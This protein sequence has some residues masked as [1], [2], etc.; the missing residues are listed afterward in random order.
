M[1]DDVIILEGCP[2]LG[3]DIVEAGDT[4]KCVYIS[5]SNPVTVDM[6]TM[7]I[8][9]CQDQFGSN[10]TLASMSDWTSKLS[11]YIQQN[12]DQR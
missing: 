6:D 3:A 11:E 4:F 9:V 7:V 8:D 2:D 5:S 1:Y 10:A 12:A